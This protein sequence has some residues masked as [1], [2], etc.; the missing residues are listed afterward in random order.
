MT[1]SETLQ[2][3]LARHLQAQPSQPRKLFTIVQKTTPE[4]LIERVVT[5]IPVIAMITD[6]G[7]N[8]LDGYGKRVLP[9]TNGMRDGSPQYVETKSSGRQFVS[10]VRLTSNIATQSKS[11]IEYFARN[12]AAARDSG[13]LARQCIA[14]PTSTQGFRPIDGIESMSWNRMPAFN[15]RVKELLQQT[16]EK[17]QSPVTKLP[18]LRFSPKAAF[19]WTNYA[20]RVE[21][22]QQPGRAFCNVR[23]AASKAAENVARLAAVIHAFDEA[24]G[25]ISLQTVETAIAMVD[26]YLKQFIRIFA[27]RVVPQVMLDAHTLD[28]W[29]RNNYSTKGFMTLYSKNWILQRGPLRKKTLLD[30]A[31]NL[32]ADGGQV[33]VWIDQKH[34]WMVTLIFNSHPFQLPQPN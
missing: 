20:N 18:I 33:Q 25:E 23:D 30:A 29:L 31:L 15:K 14:W 22:D 17:H 24:G 4:A 27:P 7:R 16:L 5:T 34:K 6:E 2:A 1:R 21:A 3:E 19:L 8:I 32:L 13:Y 11:A 9:L 26:W 12:D 28:L 10:F